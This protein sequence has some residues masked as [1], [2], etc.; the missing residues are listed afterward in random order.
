MSSLDSYL[1]D[2]MYIHACVYSDLTA[3]TWGG[4]TVQSDPEDTA[5]SAS[6]PSDVAIDTTQE[7]TGKS[8]DMLHACL[9]NVHACLNNV[10][11]CLKN[12]CMQNRL[13]MERGQL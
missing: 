4:S 7:N 2:H 11:A 1:L 13:T 3:A 6:L 12:V 8:H 5:S 9:K 10:H